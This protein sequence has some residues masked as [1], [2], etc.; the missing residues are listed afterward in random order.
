MEATQVVREPSL[1]KINPMLQPDRM[2]LVEYKRNDWVVDVEVDITLEDIKEPSFWALVADQ[3]APYDTIEVRAEDG[4]WIANLRVIFC[5]KT[6]A[7]VQIERVMEIKENMETP[8]I[9]I[10]H[11]VAWKGPHLKFVVIRLSDSQIMQ[12][13]CKTRDE[14]DVWL[15]NY[16]RTM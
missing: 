5:E 10:K 7:K 9:S 1:R 6:Y 12:S 16:E 11:K 15:R 2:G 4:K 3:M 14:A 8:Q 13:K